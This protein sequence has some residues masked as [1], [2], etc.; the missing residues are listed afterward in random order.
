[1]TLIKS[2]T[3]EWL[4]RNY[5]KERRSELA[6]EILREALH[7]HTTATPDIFQKEFWHQFLNI[8][9]KPDFL[10][11]LP[12]DEERRNWAELVFR[13]VR[14]T[15]YTLKDMMVQRVEEHSA[16]VLFRDM[17]SP[18]GVDWTYE[19]I[20]RRM[21]EFATVFY[22]EGGDQPRVAIFADNCLEGACAD[23]A[24]LSFGIF[25]TPL[26]THFSSEIL[27]G[28]FGR[29]KINIVITDTRERV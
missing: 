7:F 19:Q 23:L 10:T 24:C 13:I 2:L 28:I 27:S 11:A 26:S 4:E 15:N 25:D 20:F 21:K 3:E 17:S 29:L 14:V 1:M 5:D 9:K 6:I 12:S 16:K 22:M 18:G 8:T